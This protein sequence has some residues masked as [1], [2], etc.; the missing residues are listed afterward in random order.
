MR[1]ALRVKVV[2]EN[3]DFFTKAC[4]DTAPGRGRALVTVSVGKRGT[5]NK[6]SNN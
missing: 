6:F 1:T 2:Q 5:A 3:P 4:R